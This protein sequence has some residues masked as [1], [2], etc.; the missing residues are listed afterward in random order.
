M[1]KSPLAT[2]PHKKKAS[3]KA[4]AVRKKISPAALGYRM[5]AEWEHHDA[6]WLAWP[7]NAE[8]WPD[9]LDAVEGVYVQMIAQLTKGERV[10]V[11]VADAHDERYVYRKLTGQGI[12][13]SQVFCLRAETHDAWIRDYGPNFLV[14]EGG[15]KVALAAN[16]W[17]FN[18]WGK[19]TE[20]KV[21]TEISG[22][23]TRFL[24]IP[25][26]EPGLV[27]EGGSIDSNGLGTVLVTEECLLHRNRNPKLS[28][29]KI[30]Q[31]LFDYLA[32]RNLIWLGK[33][34]AGDDT[35]GH[36][37]DIARFVNENTVVCAVEKNQKDVNYKALEENRKRLSRAEDQDGNPLNVIE[38]P[39]PGAVKSGTARLP[40]SYLNFYIANSAVLVPIFGD[41]NDATALKILGTCFPNRAII[42]IRSESLVYGLGAIHC[43]THEQPAV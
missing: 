13:L 25:S 23:I 27:L 3:P 6:T 24:G 36:V 32:A 10:Y 38:I 33:G 31:F 28:R 22:E 40:A 37:D 11:V 43:L 20:F 41:P 35:D 16:R 29:E 21:D 9:Q 2:S 19:Y 30:E 26:F 42:G 17:I 14:K 34:I 8:T 18:G 12:R 1:K 15:S 4:K 7:H 39:M 5:P